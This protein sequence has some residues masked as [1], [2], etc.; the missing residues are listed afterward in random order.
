MIN[1]NSLVQTLIN[2]DGI[3]GKCSVLDL[4]NYFSISGDSKQST[5]FRFSSTETRPTTPSTP[6]TQA[7]APET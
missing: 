2:F 6:V 5:F 1:Q 7:T 4:I 3:V